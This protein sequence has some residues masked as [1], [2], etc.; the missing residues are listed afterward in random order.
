MARRPAWAAG[1]AERGAVPRREDA[2]STFHAPSSAGRGTGGRGD[3]RGWGNGGRGVPD[4]S[5]F[6][7]WGGSGGQ[8]STSILKW[9]SGWLVPGRRASSRVPSPQCWP[10]RPRVLASPGPP[11]HVSP[12]TQGTTHP[13][14]LTFRPR[15]P[16]WRASRAQSQAALGAGMASRDKEPGDIYSR[17][18]AAAALALRIAGRGA[19]ALR[20]V[21]PLFAAL[22]SLRPRRDSGTCSYF[23]S[24]AVRPSLFGR[25]CGR[26]VRR[27]S[28]AAGSA[29]PS[30]ACRRRAAQPP[31]PRRP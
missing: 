26:G 3:T 24:Q 14:H 10:P 1:G 7:L 20:R 4:S 9:Y 8:A 16:R 22:L 6:A 27:R 21:R 30:R 13:G 28:S 23:T 15:S 17:P 18:A 12:A 25:R 31:F 11:L 5:R 19:P 2:R 29:S